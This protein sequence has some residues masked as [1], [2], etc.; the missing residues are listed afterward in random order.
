M[1]AGTDTSRVSVE[2]GAKVETP[3]WV[4]EREIDPNGHMD[5]KT[6]GVTANLHI[7]DDKKDRF[8]IVDSVSLMRGR[9]KSYSGLY[10]YEETAVSQQ[11]GFQGPLT[12]IGPNPISISAEIGVEG[13]V[14]TSTDHSKDDLSLYTTYNFGLT[15]YGGRNVYDSPERT[16]LKVEFGGSLEPWSLSKDD[17]V[18][19]EPTIALSGGFYFK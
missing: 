16:F 13:K 8:H 7:N 5:P 17:M 6:Y 9:A 19:F 3:M 15:W 4:H 14:S 11:V 12:Q 18:E 2:V 10:S 1:V